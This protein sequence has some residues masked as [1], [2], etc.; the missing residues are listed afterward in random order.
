MNGCAYY[1]LQ[2]S[3]R[4]RYEN[5]LNTKRVLNLP[6]TIQKNIILPVVPQDLSSKN[7][8]VINTHIHSGMLH[9]SRLIGNKTVEKN[10][11]HFLLG[12]NATGVDYHQQKNTTILLFN[13]FTL[14]TRNIEKQP[15]AYV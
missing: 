8:F 7:D 15:K 13:H 4:T 12:Q 1:V 3:C 14:Q 5:N 6:K 2:I 10:L 9:H 11:Y